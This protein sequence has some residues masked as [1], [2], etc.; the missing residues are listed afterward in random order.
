MKVQQGRRVSPS[1]RGRLSAAKQQA[2]ELIE[3]LPDVCTMDDIHYHLYVR[4]KVE[5][6]IA[7]IDEGRVVP[8]AEAE[9]RVAERAK[10]YGQTPP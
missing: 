8:Q 6:G 4:E 3:S 7:A 10:S 1:K 2:I 5:R 9:Q